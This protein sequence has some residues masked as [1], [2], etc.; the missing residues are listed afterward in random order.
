M[1][2]F[3]SKN[4]EMEKLKISNSCINCENISVN[5]ICSF[6]KLE[7]NERYTCEDFEQK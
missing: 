4:L 7:V 1:I 5:S 2:I 6:H 3:L